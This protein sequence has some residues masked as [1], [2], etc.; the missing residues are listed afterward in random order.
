ML[1]NALKARH[2]QA[3]GS[4][5]VFPTTVFLETLSFRASAGSGRGGN[6]AMSPAAAAAAPLSPTIRSSSPNGHILQ[7]DQGAAM[8]T[9]IGCKGT[10]EF[11]CFSMFYV[12]VFCKST[13]AAVVFRAVP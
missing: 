1:T 5:G 3:S 11:V 4:F 8:G 2:W 7:N 13:L 9:D 12:S 6:L 10:C